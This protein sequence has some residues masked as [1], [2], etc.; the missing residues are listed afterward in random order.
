MRSSAR[1]FNQPARFFIRIRRMPLFLA[2][3]L[4]GCGGDPADVTIEKPAISPIISVESLEILT[5]GWLEGPYGWVAAESP[6]L[7]QLAKEGAAPETFLLLGIRDNDYP[8]PLTPE[9]EKIGERREP[10]EE[11]LA[12][13]RRFRAYKMDALKERC[14]DGPLWVLRMSV[15]ED[16]PAWIFL[17]KPQKGATPPTAG[18][19]WLVNAW[20]LRDG[21]ANM[22]VDDIANPFYDRMLDN[23]LAGIVERRKLKGSPSEASDI[24]RRFGITMPEEYGAQLD[25][26]ALRLD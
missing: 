4:A 3:L 21:L 2:I 23:Q 1:L 12:Q 26:M 20:L 25:Q 10:T 15:E 9:E 5:L 11:E 14:K 22:E 8:R 6:S 17:F 13:A 18:K 24:W 16:T 7:V 19:A